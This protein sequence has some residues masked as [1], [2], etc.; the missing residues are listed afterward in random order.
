MDMEKGFNELIRDLIALGG[1]PFLIL[2][3][4]RVWLLGKIYFPFQFIFG[5]LLFFILVNLFGGDKHAGLGLVILVFITMYYKTTSFT[6]FAVFVYA[7]LV[8]STLYLKHKKVVQGIFFG[9]IS[10]GISYLMTSAI[11]NTLA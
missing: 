4:A 7:M 1:I 9:V 11:F 8:M 5:A 2:V 6:I 10:T 3:I